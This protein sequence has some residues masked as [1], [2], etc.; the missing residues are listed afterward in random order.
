MRKKKINKLE[1][2]CFLTTTLEGGGAQRVLVNI[3]N[4]FARDGY[5]VHIICFV[6]KN[7]RSIYNIDSRIIV[8]NF[9]REY[10][11]DDRVRADCTRLLTAVVREIA[12]DVLIPFLM[13]VTAYA[14]KAAKKLGVKIIVS[15]RNDPVTTPNDP[16]WRKQRD[17]VF[18][19]A[20]ACVFQTQAALNYFAKNKLAKYAIIRNPIDL[21]GVRDDIVSAKNRT[22]R[23]ICVGKYESQ[24]NLYFLLDIFAEF[25]KSHPNY[26]LEVYGNDYHGNRWGLQQ[27]ATSMGLKDKVLL[28]TAQSDI[29]NVIYDARMFVL[30]SKYEGMP[31]ALIESVCIGVPSIAS[32]CPAYGG[33]M[34]VESG[35]NGFLLK[36]DDKQSFVDK[37][38]LLADDDE[39]ADRISVEGRKVREMFD[40]KEVYGKWLS[41]VSEVVCG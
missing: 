31:N 21:T 14:F 22:R 20:D 28:H 1:T 41:L 9:P 3:A 5:K 18:A 13:P 38:C 6:E 19:N 11:K 2:I 32:D 23:V 4:C 15:E 36:V 12:P 7:S 34:V 37:M 25:V 40:L 30:P 17:Y 8:H 29:L 39:L 26:R 24:K 27:R 10:S 16:F 35:K 33:R